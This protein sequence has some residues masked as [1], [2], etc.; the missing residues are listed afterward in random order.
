[1]AVMAPE[2]LNRHHARSGKRTGE[3]PFHGQIFLLFLV[4]FLALTRF[5]R[6]SKIALADSTF[7]L[8]LQRKVTHNNHISGAIIMRY[9]K[10]EDFQQNVML[11]ILYN[12]N[13]ACHTF[14]THILYVISVYSH[15]EYQQRLLT[16]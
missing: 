9:N 11:K 16:Y 6:V 8:R 7:L 14:D 12:L 10:K 4:V 15:M 3:E 1:M 13:F 2:N 5:L